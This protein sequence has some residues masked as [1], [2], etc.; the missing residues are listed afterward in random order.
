MSPKVGKDPGLLA[1]II[2]KTDYNNYQL[3]HAV[4]QKLHLC[5]YR[6]TQCWVLRST[7]HW[8]ARAMLLIFCNYR[9]GCWVLVQKL[10]CNIFICAGTE[11]IPIHIDAV[12][13]RPSLIGWIS[14]RITWNPIMLI[15]AP[16]AHSW[17][18]SLI[19]CI[20][21]YKLPYNIFL[22]VGFH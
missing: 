14:P 18:M 6:S 4:N 17:P 11:Y 13:R 1:S 8:L 7:L 20:F 16:C 12:P 3:L 9:L 10:S 2:C 19:V 15:S 21:V 22:Y 5:I